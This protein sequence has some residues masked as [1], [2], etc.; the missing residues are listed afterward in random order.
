M[1]SIRQRDG[2]YQVRII[3][4]G[5]RALTRTFNNRTDA[6]KW[7]RQA[8]VEIER[9]AIQ[10]HA[11]SITLSEAIARYRKERTRQKKSARS[12]R[13]L[14]DAWARSQLAAIPLN[15]I[16]PTQIAEWRDGRSSSG[17]AAQTIR[18]G[19]TVLSAIYEQAIREWG[20]D[21]LVNPVRRIRRPPA[22]KPRNRRVSAQELAAIKTATASPHLSDLIDLAVETGM[23]L[24][25]LV[26]IRPNMVDFAARTVTLKDSKNGHGRVVPLSTVA[27]RILQKRSSNTIFTERLLPMT[28]HSATVAFKRAVV[29]A[30]KKLLQKDPSSLRSDLLTD[31]RFH[32]LRREATTRFFERGLDLVSVA[33]ITGHKVAEMVRRYTA[34]HA[35]DLAEKLDRYEPLSTQSTVC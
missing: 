29:R 28:S 1:A 4:K 8:E 33:S 18:N 32:D 20:H 6:I 26:S 35:S 7:A 23:R 27:L 21:Q 12:E 5:H 15:R 31:L 3:R 14:L 22:P 10:M 9:G 11:R 24:G 17:A 34:F 25:E 30:R 19:L 16:R 2:K 13:Y